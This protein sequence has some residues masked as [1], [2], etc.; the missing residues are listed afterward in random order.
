MCN[1]SKL[2]RSN[3]NSRSVKKIEL[4]ASGCWFFFS[5]LKTKVTLYT[6]LKY[7]QNNSAYRLSPGQRTMVGDHCRGYKVTDLFFTQHTICLYKK[8]NIS[9][10]NNFH[11]C[12]L[13]LHTTVNIN[14]MVDSIVY[15]IL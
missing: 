1:V 7:L 14:S 2:K 12:L 9:Y 8:N 5:Q 6:A 13:N 10:T 11:P 15:I 3:A 4:D